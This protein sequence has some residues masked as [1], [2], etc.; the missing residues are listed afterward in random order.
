MVQKIVSF[1][2]SV[3]LILCPVITMAVEQTGGD[4]N[5]AIIDATRDAKKET[6]FPLWYAAGCV[7]TLFGIGAAYLIVPSPQPTRFMGKPPDYINAYV[8][9]YRKVIRSRQTISAFA[10]CATTVGAAIII[11]LIVSAQEA[12]NNPESCGCTVDDPFGLNSCVTSGNDCIE[13]TNNCLSTGQGCTVEGGSCMESSGGC[14]GG[15][16]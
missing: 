13:G 5:Q 4:T 6:N 1:Y 14:L 16:E 3:F 15:G 8:L 11:G 2:L 7:F 9:Q 10:G 12:E